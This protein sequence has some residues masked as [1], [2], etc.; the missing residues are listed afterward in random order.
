[1]SSSKNTPK[2]GTVSAA[3][4]GLGREFVFYPLDLLVFVMNLIFGVSCLLNLGK[5]SIGL[6]RWAVDR[7]LVMGIV[8]LALNPLL[9]L[10]IRLVNPLR[11]QVPQFFRMAYAQALYILYFTECIWLSQLMYNGASLDGFFARMDYLIFRFQ[12]AI[13]FSR[14][15]QEFPIVNEMFFFSYFFYYALISTGVWFLFARRRYAAAARMLFIISGSFFILY[16]WFVFFP[17]KGPKY[18][19]DELYQI[20]YSNFRGFFF[21]RIVKGLFNNTN[22]GGAA[23][24]SSHVA[25]AII[26]ILLNWRHN[27]FVVPI[28]LPLTVL[29]LLSTIY[30]YAHYFVDIPA[31]AIAGVLLFF[32]VP[33][34]IPSTAAAAARMGAWFRERLGFRPVALEIAG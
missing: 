33:R 25:L 22:L 5:I 34:L 15:F 24:P 19:F 23:F 13:Q 20:W 32:T 26:S 11:G 14:H 8:F 9:L 10:G 16:V 2:D 30:L 4:A 12:P 28:Y 29:L 6:F 1:M 31:G 17:V 27:R 18:Y 7:Q 21:T 3:A